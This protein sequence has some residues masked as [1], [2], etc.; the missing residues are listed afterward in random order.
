M[1]GVNIIPKMTKS[2]ESD[3]SD[4]PIIDVQKYMN[5]DKLAKEECRK[6]VRSLHEHGILIVKDT[7]SAT[8][9]YNRFV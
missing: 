5:N 3:T 4:I 1:P 2:A 8:D 7:V 9:A 6:V